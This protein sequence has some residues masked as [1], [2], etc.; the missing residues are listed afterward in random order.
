[1]TTEQDVPSKA[2]LL[3]A[4]R[5]SGQELLAKLG[6]LPESEFEQGRYEGGWNARQILALVAS[7]EWTYPRLLDVA[8][9]AQP[10]PQAT[11]EAP[12]QPDRSEAKTASGPPAGAARGGIEDYSQRQVDKRAGAS[13]AELLAEFEK[14]RAATIAAIEGADEALLATPITSAGGITG[15]LAGVIQALS[16]LHVLGH[17]KD[18]VGEA[19]GGTV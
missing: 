3:E 15:A 11:G 16:V 9:Q 7:I 6:A 18:I 14:N 10:A 5:S 4:L 12:D 2:V 13:V 17:V 19:G 1:M 8:R